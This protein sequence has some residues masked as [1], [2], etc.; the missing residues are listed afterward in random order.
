[1][2]DRFFLLIVESSHDLWAPIC[3]RK[4]GFNFWEVTDIASRLSDNSDTS[5]YCYRG[6]DFE[7]VNLE[8]STDLVGLAIQ[9]GGVWIV[10]HQQDAEV[11]K[12][13]ARMLREKHKDLL[14]FPS[15]TVIQTQSTLAST[16]RR[17]PSR[18]D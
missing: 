18:H 16:G 1:M 4:E 14:A 11:E 10:T 15:F 8:Q 2:G 6:G 7:L 3:L 17:D 13:R 12:N 9:F 5:R